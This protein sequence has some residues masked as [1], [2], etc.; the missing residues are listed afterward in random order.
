MAADVTRIHVLNV[1]LDVVEDEDLPKVIKRICHPE[2]HKQII[3]LDF[4]DFMIARRSKERRA[5]LEDAALVIPISSRIT[6]AAKFVK[7]E[8]PP[9]RRSYPFVIRLLSIME[10]LGETT[11]LLGSTMKGVRQAESM[12][13]TSFPGL[14][15]VGRYAAR[16]PEEREQDVV[17][18]IKKAAPTLLLAGKG[19]KGQY[20]WISRR[21][22][23]FA[24]GLSLWERHCFGVFSGKHAKPN[25]S[26][27]ARFSRTFFGFFIRPWR[28]LRIF[29]NMFFHLLVLVERLKG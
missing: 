21:R 3:L 8:V 23:R 25:E 16:F 5:I 24:P 14:G 7:K 12:I 13:R 22:S 18:A 26:A 11:Y 6:R 9:L 1:P 29:R 2:Q 20:L 4:Q 27:G 19:L 10:N 17:T 15:I 28:L